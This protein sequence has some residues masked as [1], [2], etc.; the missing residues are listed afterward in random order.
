MLLCLIFER[1][2]KFFRQ[3][4]TITW[5]TVFHVRV[6][7]VRAFHVRVF[8]VC[9]FHVKNPR[10]RRQP[11]KKLGSCIWA[12]LTGGSK[13]R[14]TGHGSPD[15]VHGFTGH[16][17]RVYGSCVIYYRSWVTVYHGS[18]TTG[19]TFRNPT[20]TCTHPDCLFI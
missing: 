16:G 10:W 18:C 3:T 13:I 14:V 19:Q 9:V 4:E 7:H 12:F 11:G 17:S 1:N 8:H 5:Q 15:T 20:L 2:M 6:F